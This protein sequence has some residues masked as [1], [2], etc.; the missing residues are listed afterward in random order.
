MKKE[1]VHQSNE[2]LRTQED[3]GHQ[4]QISDPFIFTN[5]EREAQ[6]AMLSIRNVISYTIS[7]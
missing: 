1:G 2:V 4:L 6:R 5:E 7:C 3:R